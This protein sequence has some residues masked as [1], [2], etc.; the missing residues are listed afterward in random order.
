[1]IFRDISSTDR[2][3]VP[4]TCTAPAAASQPSLQSRLGDAEVNPRRPPWPDLS[5]TD[6]TGTPSAGPPL[7]GRLRPAHPF[8]LAP[9]TPTERAVAPRR[10]WRNQHLAPYGPTRHCVLPVMSLL[11]SKRFGVGPVAWAEARA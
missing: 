7:S 10:G 6:T 9:V 3:V 5:G 4:M 1:M 11:P 8:S 2:P